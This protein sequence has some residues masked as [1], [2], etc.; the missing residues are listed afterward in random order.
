[1]RLFGVDISRQKAAAPQAL[2]A[3]DG[4]RGWWPIVVREAFTGAWQRNQE[5][6]LDTAFTNPTLFRCISLISSDIAKMRVKLV[7]LDE[8]GI[9]TET[10]S[11][12][13]SPVLTK[14]N[15]YQNRIQ[16]YTSWVQSKLSTGNAVV[17]K[18][19]D[20][21]GVVNG[22]HVLDWH[23]CKPLVA[24]DGSVFYDLHT[25]NLS[26]IQATNVQVPAS[27]VIH[28][29][30]NT[31]FHPLVGLSP[32]YACGLAALEG[33][34][35]Q[36]ASTRFFRNGS[37]PSG[38]LTAPGTIS[39]ETADRMKQSWEENYGGDNIGKTA[40]LGD[41]LKYEPMAATAHDSQLAEQLKMSAETICGCYGV[42]SY[43]A[44]VG[45][46]PLNNNVQSLA[47]L[48]YAQCLQIH[49]ESVE[50]CLDEG[51]GLTTGAGQYGTEFDLDGLL[52]MD[53]ATQVKTLVE[54]V[55]GMLMQPNEARK[56][57]SLPPTKGGDAVYGQQQDFSLAALAD[58][59]SNKPF[60]KPATPPAALPAPDVSSQPAA[61]NDDQAAKNLRR[62]AAFEARFAR[63]SQ[64]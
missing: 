7:Q 61:A 29:R 56:A 6:R 8:N 21:R 12:A 43:M 38:V 16:F 42:P 26:G 18:E 36:R 17:L 3:V 54:A 62:A 30:W 63:G 15:R 25:D 5:L 45:A 31:L 19:R 46:A 57:L 51:L 44:G 49:I 60:A 35:I 41:G 14:P 34:E 37:K 9:W 4:S 53:T 47:E 55:G 48:Y 32:I 40:V 24:A 52:R 13:F 50:L 22:L 39:K 64:R 23:R 1:L 33:V 10:K 58:R 20:A 11:A 27:E 59:D 28:D 2:S